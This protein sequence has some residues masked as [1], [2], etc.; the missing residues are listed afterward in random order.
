[1]TRFAM[2]AGDFDRT[3]AVAENLARANAAVPGVDGACARAG[4]ALYRPVMSWIVAEME[5]GTSPLETLQGLV[6]TLANMVSSV[7]INADAGEE[8][9]GAVVY[10]CE[11]LMREAIGRLNRARNPE[12]ATPDL[13]QPTRRVAAGTA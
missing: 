9:E 11:M 13:V 3:C 6:P 10:V 4:L 2:H 12:T 1:M 5:R 8:A 7:V